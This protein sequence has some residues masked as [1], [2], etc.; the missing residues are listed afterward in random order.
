MSGRALFAIARNE[1]A[2]FFSDRRGVLFTL[3]TPIAIA[4][5]FGFIFSGEGSR[6]T[7]KVAVLVADRDHSAVSAA[8][9]KGLASDALLAVA[10]AGEEAAREAVRRGKAAV[11]VVLPPGFGE[12]AGR[13]FFSSGP[14]PEVG[15]LYDPSHGTEMA[16]VRGILT[17]Y[18]MQAV[19]AEVFSGPS[20]ARLARESKRQL[21]SSPGIDPA[22]RDAL[23]RLLDGVE[24]WV[25]REQKTGAGAERPGF[26]GLTIPYAVREEAVT[27]GRGVAYNG[28]AHSFAGMGIQFVLFAAIELGIGVLM[29]REGGVWRRLRAAPLTRATVL[30]GK[31][32]GGAL[33]AAVTLGAT[34]G[35]GMLFFGVRVQGSWPGFLMLCAASCLMAASF[36]L[37]LAALGRTTQATRGLAILAVLLMTMLGGGWV[38]A[39]LFPAWM[40]ALTLAVPTRWAVDGLDAVT[41]RG[42]GFEG[43]LAP[44]L[45]LAGFAALFGFVVLWRFRW[46]E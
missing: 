12:A 44:S 13:A 14:K 46:E 10:P 6:E 20:G 24:G 32:L 35:A 7:A 3:A 38:P 25:S 15:F 2:R 21:L 11:A 37:L 31:A 40:Q 27:S 19:S 39:F 9:A 18:A 45:V 29:E 16:M 4:A 43:A 30:G 22:E 33:I 1:L 26:A 23:V 34:L 42:V 5:F 41:W 8:L 36:G 17:E 28:Y